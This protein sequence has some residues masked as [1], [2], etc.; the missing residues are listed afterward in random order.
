MA[1]NNNTTIAEKVAGRI[2][3]QYLPQKSVYPHLYISRSSRD[4]DGTID[5]EDGIV[6]E[7][8]IV[9]LVAKDY[10]ESLCDSVQEVL[11]NLE[12]SLE[13]VTVHL[14]DMEDVADNYVFTSA[15]SDALFIHGFKPAVYFS[16]VG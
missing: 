2:H 8:Y 1:L 15:D 10:D 6:V 16:E 13:R 11:S 12:C 5:G 14:V 3:Y 9:E 7:R 4:T